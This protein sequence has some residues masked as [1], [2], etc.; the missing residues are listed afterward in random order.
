MKVIHSIGERW[1]RNQVEALARHGI[2]VTEDVLSYIDVEPAQFELIKDIVLPFRPIHSIGAVFGRDDLDGAQWLALTALRVFGYPQP[3]LHFD[4]SQVYETSNRCEKCGLNRGRQVRPFRI[5]SDKTALEAF[6]L[7][8]IYDEVFVKRTFYEEMFEPLGIGSW[9]VLIHRSGEESGSV[10]QLDLPEPDWNFDMKGMRTEDCLECSQSK[11]VV[12]PM[13][14]LPPP[15]GGPPNS[16]FRGR[17]FYGSGAQALK[18]IYLSQEI[19]QEF[20]N[21]RI[22]KWHQFYP[23]AE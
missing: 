17:E 22:A 9:P 3:E 18:R 19:R 14:F 15:N 11:Y 2:I 12:R 6:Q 4:V 10:V 21:R 16:I 1:T 7:E 20:L 23:L 13:G 8:W 5:K